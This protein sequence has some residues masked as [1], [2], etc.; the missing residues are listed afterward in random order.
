MIKRKNHQRGF[1]PA[2]QTG[3]P[4]ENE[5]DRLKLQTVQVNSVSEYV[6][7]LSTFEQRHIASWFYRGHEDSSYKLVPGLYRHDPR[8]A[9]SDWDEM[10]EY[11]TSI[12]KLE[13]TPFLSHPP[14]HDL[15]WLVLAQHHGLPTR[16]L[17]WTTNPLIGLYFAVAGRPERDADV[18]CLGFHSTNNCLTESTY[19][20]RRKTLKKSEIIY[21]PKHLSPRVT[22]QSGCFT[23]HKSPIPLNEDEEMKWLFAFTRVQIIASEKP[24]ILD[25]LYNLGIHRGFI[26]PGLEGIAKRLV[27]EVSTKNFRHTNEPD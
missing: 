13:A 24:R 23:I 1:G 10:E 16:L 15:D 14:E 6:A 4:G 11:M 20:A 17:D 12:F 8:E 5:R 25:E 9:F 2:R 26:Y 22:N 21:F 19:F 3:V 18:W 27:Y 7:L